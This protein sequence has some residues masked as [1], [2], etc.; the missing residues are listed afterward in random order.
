MGSVCVLSISMWVAAEESRMAAF[1]R[2]A[3]SLTQRNPSM[4]SFYHN[5]LM[6]YRFPGSS[7]KTR[8]KLSGSLGEVFS[9]GVTSLCPHSHFQLLPVSAHVTPAAGIMSQPHVTAKFFLAFRQYQSHVQVC[10]PEKE[11]RRNGEK[12]ME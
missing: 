4:T 11:R 2:L 5:I 3:A 9:T 1:G 6:F 10:E 7:H 8:Q 12:Q